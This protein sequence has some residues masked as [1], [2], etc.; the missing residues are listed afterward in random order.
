MCSLQISTL[1]VHSALTLRTNRSANAY[2]NPPYH[3]SAQ[4]DAGHGEWREH[5]RG[6]RM[7]IILITAMTVKKSC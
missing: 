6:R 7:I 4:P 3:R 1:P 5:R 2:P